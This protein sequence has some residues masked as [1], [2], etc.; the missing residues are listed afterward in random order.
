LVII[1]QIY[2][3]FI[4]AFVKKQ[5]KNVAVPFIFYLFTN[6]DFGIFFTKYFLRIANL[7]TKLLL[8]PKTQK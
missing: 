8:L 5:E 2:G 3:F 7:K 6:F 1:S 4:S